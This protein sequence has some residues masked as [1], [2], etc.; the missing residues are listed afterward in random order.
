MCLFVSTLC[1]N[2]AN[3]ISIKTMQK[4]SWNC[5]QITRYQK[6]RVQ[7]TST[8]FWGEGL[9]YFAD[10]NYCFNKLYLSY[11]FWKS[12]FDFQ[13]FHV[14]LLQ[15]PF[16]CVS[17]S[18]G[19]LLRGDEWSVCPTHSLWSVCLNERRNGPGDTHTL[20]V[21]QWNTKQHTLDH[22]HIMVES[23]PQHNPT[24]TWHYSHRWSGQSF[25]SDGSAC[26]SKLSPDSH[27]RC[28]RAASSSNSDASDRSAPSV[29]EP[30]TMSSTATSIH[31]HTQPDSHNQ[32]KSDTSVCW[33]FCDL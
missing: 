11:C 3:F 23:M 25:H 17:L 30:H 13:H 10:F 28:G 5:S 24:H 8:S 26:A 22:T 14:S 12:H 21:T 2:E 19:L 16:L 7:E 31:R 20:S 33:W 1:M 6:M 32:R 27:R 9:V 29:P 15:P 4:L 18:V